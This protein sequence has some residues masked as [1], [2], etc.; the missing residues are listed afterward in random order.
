MSASEGIPA[1]FVI[2][3]INLSHFL[4]TI[5]VNTDYVTRGA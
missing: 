5:A 1:H 3:K 2:T 4:L